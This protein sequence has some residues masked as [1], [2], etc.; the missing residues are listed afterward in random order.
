MNTF[1][2]LN[3]GRFGSLTVALTLLIMVSC[4]P[5]RVLAEYI[6][7]VDVNKESSSIYLEDI[8]TDIRYLK[9]ESKKDLL[10]AEVSKLAIGDSSIFIFDRKQASIFT[11]DLNGQIKYVIKNP[12]LSDGRKFEYIRD[13]YYDSNSKH[14]FVV[15]ANANII[16][17]FEAY[18]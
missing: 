4:R 8:A 2:S 5:D 7:E 6:I 18:E 3:C 17:E 11:F 16:Y 9:L 1:I 12:S 10:I 14:L 15:D 13:I